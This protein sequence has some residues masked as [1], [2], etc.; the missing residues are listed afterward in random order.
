MCAVCVLHHIFASFRNTIKNK[1]FT[2]RILIKQLAKLKLHIRTTDYSNTN[3]VIHFHKNNPH[4][5]LCVCLYVSVCSYLNG[6]SYVNSV[7][8]EKRLLETIVW[9]ICVILGGSILQLLFLFYILVVLV[10]PIHNAYSS[11]YFT[12]SHSTKCQKACFVCEGFQ[13]NL[14]TLYTQYFNFKW[15]FMH[16]V[17][18]GIDVNE[19]H[20]NKQTSLHVHLA[21]I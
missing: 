12:G 19:T 4:V 6:I 9:K 11:H 5:C 13:M 21:T 16:T 15:L 7:Y 1:A 2:S 17:L 18:N 20:T 3:T 10:D 8:K 14:E